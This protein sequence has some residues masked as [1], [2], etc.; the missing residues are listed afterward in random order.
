MVKIYRPNELYNTP[1]SDK[2]PAK[3]GVFNVG[4]STFYD[5]IEPDLEKV[6]LAT[7]AVGYTDRSVEEKIAKGIAE[8]A[9]ERDAA[10]EKIHTSDSRRRRANAEAA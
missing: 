1:A 2:R 3:R 9:A 5:E 10:A 7:R 4:K 8:A 6:N